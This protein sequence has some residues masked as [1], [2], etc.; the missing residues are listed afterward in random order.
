MRVLLLLRGSPAS[1]KSTWIEQNVLKPYTLSAD[2]IRLLYSSPIWNPDGTRSINQKKNNQA[3]NTLYAILENRMA[4]GEFTVIDAT[5]SKTAEMNRMKKLAQ[6]YRYRVY[7]VDFTN[8]PMEEVIKRNENREEYKRVPEKAIL[9]QYAR[10][11]TQ[12]VPSGITVISPNELEKIQYRPFDASDYKA[13]HIFGDIHGCYTALREYFKNEELDMAVLPSDELFIFLGDYIDRGLES[14][15]VM[16]FLLNIMDNQNVFLLEGNHEKRLREWANDNDFSRWSHPFKETVASFEKEN[17]TKKD[18]KRFCSR[19]GQCCLF[20]YYGIEYLVTHGGISKIPEE[21]LIFVPTRDM[22]HGVGTYEDSK[23]CDETFTDTSKQ[24]HVERFQI[25]GHRNILREQ[26]HNTYYTFNLECRVEFGGQLRVVKLTPTSIEPIE[27]TNTVFKKEVRTSSDEEFLESVKS[28]KGNDFVQSLRDNKNILEKSFGEVSSFNFTREAFKKSSWDAMTTRARGLYLDNQTGDVRIR[29]YD[30]F[31][32][33]NERDE[34]SIQALQDTFVFPVQG[35]LKENGFLTLMSYIEG[36]GL[37]IA[38]KTTLEGDHVDIAKKVFHTLPD[39]VQKDVEQFLKDNNCTLVFECC[40]SQADPHII[41][42]SEPKLVLLECIDN[43]L[44]Y[45]HDRYSLLELHS[46]ALGLPWIKKHTH[47]FNNWDEFY[48]EYVA[49]CK[50]G[51]KYN[52]EYV[53]GFVFEDANGFMVKL[54]TDYYKSQ[55]N[56]RGMASIIFRT[57]TFKYTGSLLTPYDNKFYKYCMDIY[58]EAEK[59]E[60]KREILDEIRKL[61]FINLRNYFELNVSPQKVVL[62]EGK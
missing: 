11:E 19:L 55:K 32:N 57:G 15:K 22:V 62:L 43:D 6:E 45:S 44:K 3:W 20:N 30:K 49:I 24:L 10:F 26:S 28:M 40:D 38:T 1:G 13:V 56:L 37:T 59:Y 46:Q 14:E 54:K 35:Y 36:K 25:H 53:E 52:G 4:D 51:Y 27:V 61:S 33:I 31:F 29:G 2:D 48:N 18:M 23:T 58:H 47:T 12:K 41:E 7:L 17:I 60:N 21:G 8:V 5:M 50:E 9:N 34:T 39:D 42:Y 16:K